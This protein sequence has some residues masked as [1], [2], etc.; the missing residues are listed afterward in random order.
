MRARI[1]T[2]GLTVDRT[3][4]FCALFLDKG[5]GRVK[6]NVRL[7][8]QVCRAQVF[9]FNISPDEHMQGLRHND[10]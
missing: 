8:P 7:Q 1:E 6:K 9:T 10:A 3:S 4:Q 5:L 2:H